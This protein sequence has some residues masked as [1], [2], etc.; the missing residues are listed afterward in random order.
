VPGLRVV[1]GRAP[2]ALTELDADRDPPDAV[3]VGG[4][5]SA[6]G[7][8]DTV[9]AALRPGGRLVANAVTVEGET[10]LA[11]FRATHGGALRRI[12]VERAEPV[13]R[14]VGWRA[15]AG[16]TQLVQRKDPA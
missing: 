15:L 5:V 12:G 3:F 6:P 4:G 16:V 14:F 8:L 10:A 1:V 11:A 7:M 9:W 13:G 2:E